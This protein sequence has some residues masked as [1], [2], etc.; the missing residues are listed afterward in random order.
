MAAL[1]RRWSPPTPRRAVATV[2][3]SG[4]RSRNA[5]R[6]QEADTG[7]RVAA[8]GRSAQF[9]GAWLLFRRSRCRPPE[10]QRARIFGHTLKAQQPIESQHV[11]VMSR[12]VERRKP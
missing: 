4:H 1:R 8:S 11:F 6:G 5:Q 12:S 7:N 3:G 2:Y 10:V 9:F